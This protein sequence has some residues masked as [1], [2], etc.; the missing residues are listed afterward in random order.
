GFL[1]SFA[2]ESCGHRLKAAAVKGRKPCTR[3]HSKRTRRFRRYYLVC[4]LP[5]LRAAVF[6][7][8]EQR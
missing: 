5:A 2:S 8:V 7:E 1:T 3:Q 4:V 6:P